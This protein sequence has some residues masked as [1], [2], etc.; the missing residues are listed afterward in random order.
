MVMNDLDI[1]QRN[2]FVLSQ[3]ESA[4]CKTKIIAPLHALGQRI[5]SWHNNCVC[6][7]SDDDHH[8]DIIDIIRG[9]VLIVRSV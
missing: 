9:G 7:S 1:S 4:D 8:D 6:Y 3:T 5:Y 2:K